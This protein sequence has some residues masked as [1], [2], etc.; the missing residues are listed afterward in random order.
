[1]NFIRSLETSD[2]FFL[3]NTIEVKASEEEGTGAAKTA[4]TV[5]LSLALETFFYK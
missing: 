4:G 5:S 2:T 3:I 1:V